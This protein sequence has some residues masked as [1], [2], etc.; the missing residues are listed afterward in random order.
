MLSNTYLASGYINECDDYDHNMNNTED[1]FKD[2]GDF[3]GKM[4]DDVLN[5]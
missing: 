3:E 2:I 4:N 5:F 1:R